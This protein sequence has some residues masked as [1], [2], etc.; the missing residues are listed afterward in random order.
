M[1]VE[2]VSKKSSSVDVSV[3]EA[4]EILIE[5][6]EKALKKEKKIG[7]QDD[8]RREEKS[9]EAYGKLRKEGYVVPT[10]EYIRNYF[11]KAPYVDDKMSLSRFVKGVDKVY[12]N[13]FNIKLLEQMIANAKDYVKQEREQNRMAKKVQESERKIIS[14]IYRNGTIRPKMNLSEFEAKK[15]H[16]EIKTTY[17]PWGK[18][19]GKNSRPNIREGLIRLHCNGNECISNVVDIETVV[20]RQAFTAK[21]QQF[22]FQKTDSEFKQRC[23][24]VAQRIL[25]LTTPHIIRHG[26][27]NGFSMRIF[28]DR[29][30]RLPQHL[31]K[32]VQEILKLC[33]T[34][35][36]NRS[37][38]TPGEADYIKMVEFCE[39][40]IHLNPAGMRRELTDIKLG[41]KIKLQMYED[42][43]VES[44]NS[45][46][47]D[48]SSSSGEE[49]EE[50]EAAEEDSA[51]AESD[52]AAEEDSAA[53]ESADS[54]AEEDETDASDD[55]DASVSDG[56]SGP[57]SDF[58]NSEAASDAESMTE[59]VYGDEF[60]V[61]D[62][63]IVTHGK[64]KGQ[65]GRIDSITAQKYRL[66]L[67][68]EDTT[69]TGKLPLVNKDDVQEEEAAEEDSSAA[70]SADSAD[71]E[72]DID[73]DYA[74]D[75]TAIRASLNKEEEATEEDSA[76]AES[77]DS[78][79]EEEESQE[80]QDW[81]P[82]SKRP[83]EGT[84]VQIKNQV[85]I[86]VHNGGWNELDGTDIRVN[87]WA[88]GKVQVQSS[89]NP[90]LMLDSSD[91]EEDDA[92]KKT[93]SLNPLLMLDSSD[94]EEDDARKNS[95]MMLASSDED[96]DR[97]E[98]E[99]GWRWLTKDDERP[100]N[101]VQIKMKGPNGHMHRGH[102]HRGDPAK[103]SN[104]KSS[105]N[106]LVDARGTVIKVNNK[107]IHTNGYIN[108]IQVPVDVS[109]KSTIP[110]SP[111]L[112]PGE[113]STMLMNMSD[114][115]ATSDD[116][117][118]AE[119]SSN[120]FQ[121]NYTG[122]TSAMTFADSSSDHDD[123]HL[124]FAP[125][126]STSTNEK[127]SS[128]MEFAA[129]SSDMGTSEMSFAGTSDSDQGHL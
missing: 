94:D 10:S 104:P 116:E 16:W 78:A 100:K 49:E 12:K 107:T 31:D 55:E 73:V 103:G 125:E 113:L 28:Q 21:R 67:D 118:F 19:N 1:E 64:W 42:N 43:K 79:E 46:S 23:Q 57:D 87:G 27:A 129:T 70:E 4:K 30:G 17:Q 97:I 74:T 81:A 61:N 39:P 26:L 122:G 5:K 63:V 6:M 32:N 117:L 102:M 108:K 98:S 24:G 34:K 3:I 123:T 54:A 72:D 101:G 109:R 111:N 90:L 65:T 68:T 105:H 13:Q 52:S 66:R 99:H 114:D 110:K 69:E 60:N 89:R 96:N 9:A 71:E 88:N 48:S 85:G 14:L 76:A 86:L 120:E 11:G 80:E 95:L 51:V 112:A 124:T 59:S 18:L 77:A 62:R 38:V 121:F 29:V 47:E 75:L 33:Q 106:Y 41:K 2:I 45:S 115:W 36:S 7:Q 56:I 126:S 119:D 25:R 53:A 37:K 82:A 50:E 8:K 127:T 91:D 35:L 22:R 44:D 83:N 128:D 40:T 93:F 58:D 15:Y 84:Q 20:R 92:N